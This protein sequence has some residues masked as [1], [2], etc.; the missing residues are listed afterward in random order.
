[1]NGKEPKGTR[2]KILEATGCLLYLA[3][4]VVLVAVFLAHC[5]GIFE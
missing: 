2:R 5:G 3:A 4:A 1:V